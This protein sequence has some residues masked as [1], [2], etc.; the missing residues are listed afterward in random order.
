MAAAAMQDAAARMA[1]APPM[2]VA[3]TATATNAFV[4]NPMNSMLF[5][6]A[7]QMLGTA[8]GNNPALSAMSALSAAMA[9]PP[10]VDSPHGGGSDD[11]KFDEKDKEKE[12]G[13]EPEKVRRRPTK[14]A[15]EFFVPDFSKK[16][17]EERSSEPALEKED[18]KAIRTAARLKWDEMN[19]EEREP[20]EQMRQEYSA[21]EP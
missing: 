7:L 11:D 16:R 20:Y 8:D 17:A 15:F 3:P 19:A 14:S 2:P 6:S 4:A 10:V 5:P 21:Q 13:K 1:G 12:D 9:H 18:R